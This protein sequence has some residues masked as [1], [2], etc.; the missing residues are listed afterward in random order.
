ML[1]KILRSNTVLTISLLLSSCS[2]LD[3]LNPYETCQQ[4]RI[5]LQNQCNSIGNGQVSQPCED[6]KK[7]LASDLCKKQPQQKNSSAIEL[8]E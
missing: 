2:V 4:A 3:K 1:I 6:A 7:T 5:T 8:L